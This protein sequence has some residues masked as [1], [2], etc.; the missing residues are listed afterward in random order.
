MPRRN[1]YL[2]NTPL[3]EALDCYL[4]SVRAHISPRHELIPTEDA[5]GRVTTTPTYARISSPSY[6]AAA[7]DG[8]T[9]VAARTVGA[10]ELNPLRLTA[11]TDYQVIDTGDPVN[12]PFDAVIMAEDVIELVTFDANGGGAASAGGTVAVGGAGGTVAVGGAAAAVATSTAASAAPIATAAPASA[13]TAT[14]EIIAAVA[15]W[16][17]VRP[18]GED[19]AQAEMLLPSHHVVRPVDIGLLLSGGI[20]TLEV[21]ARPHVAII[22]TG[23]ELIEP[24]TAPHSTPSAHTPSAPQPAAARPC[25]PAPPSTYSAPPAPPSV[26]ST[27]PATS[28]APAPGAIID[29][30]S[31][32]IAALVQESGGTAHRLPIVADDYATL[33][34]TIAQAAATHDLVL[35]NAGSSAGTEDYTAPILRELGEVLI[36]GVAIKPGKPVI[37]ALVGGTPVIGLPGYPLATFFNFT[38]FVKPVMELFT[39]T[40][41]ANRAKIRA[42]L[43]KRLVSSLKFREY[44][45][46]NV[47]LVGE[48]LIAAP[49]SRGSGVISSL[50]RADGYLVIDQNLEGLEA[51]TQV[52]VSLYRDLYEVTHTVLAIGSHDLAL[53]IIADLMPHLH[54]HTHLSSTHVGSLAGL[55]ALKRGE[56]HLAPC[57]LL[58]EVTGLYNIPTIQ[59]IFADEPMA[60]IKGLGRIQGLMVPPGNPLAIRGIKDLRRV[61]CINR[62]RGAGTRL[63]LDYRLKEAGIEPGAIKGYEREATTHMAVASAI[64]AGSADTGLGVQSAATALGLDFV[65]IGCEEYDFALPQ[66]FLNLEHIQAFIAV[67]KSP[68]LRTALEKLGGYNFAHT[69]EIILIPP[70]GKA[71]TGC[72]GRV[73]PPA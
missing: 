7:M 49:L 33:K 12:P 67:L 17:N 45:Q 1:L 28:A 47:G 36:H 29:S 19:F 41:R 60:L 48:K 73:E 5:L 38:I 34:A 23:T 66:S 42:T 25:T 63:L 43:A 71:Y 46:V 51:G 62:Q 24:E 2:Q 50:V 14:V 22:P 40:P 70:L 16:T 64:A 31:R 57:H 11:G 26:R 52:E 15:P 55:G 20:T 53:D 30:N 21:T 9:V 59:E 8:I 6:N 69:G 58:D 72:A 68:E 61:S 18:I 10:S 35:V 3:K 27:P 4:A 13:S 44:V 37:L 56:A 39:K 32:M 65:E 54:R